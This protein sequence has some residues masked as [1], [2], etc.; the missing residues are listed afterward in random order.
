M[1]MKFDFGTEMSNGFNLFK[2]NMWPLVM[3]SLVCVLLSAL[4]FGIIAAPMSIG[5]F[6]IIRRFLKKEQPAPEVG[7]LFKGFAF[8]LNSF[9]FFLLFIF[10]SVVLSFIPVLGQVAS[11]CLGAFLWWGLMFI[12]FENLSVGDA[13]KQLI[14]E[15]KSGDFFLHLLFAVVAGLIS[16][17]GFL[18]CCVGMFFTFP[19]AYCMMACCYEASYGKA[20]P[21]QP[22]DPSVFLN[23]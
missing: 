9:L 3:A 17:A 4:S 14:N 19:I 11:F 12:A 2:E 10:A 20:A 16:S 21:A 7:D 1:A 18:V 6:L 22:L 13:I 5:L 8:F 15:T 23:Q